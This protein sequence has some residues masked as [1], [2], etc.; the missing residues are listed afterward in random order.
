[1]KARNGILD[2]KID[3]LEN[4][5]KMVEGELREIATIEAA[6]YS[7]VA[8]HMALTTGLIALESKTFSCFTLA[9]VLLTIKDKL[10]QDKVTAGN[11]HLSWGKLLSILVVPRD[12]LS[13]SSVSVTS[14]DLENRLNAFNLAFDERYKK[15]SNWVIS[16]EILRENVCK[17]LVEGII[18]IYR[19]HVK[20]YCLSIENDAK[21]DKYMKYMA[22]SLENKIGSLFQPKQRKVTDLTLAAL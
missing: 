2:N 22:Q 10:F 1:M 9:V 8:D 11:T 3:Y 21:V 7:V 4:K 18:P 6:L 15:Q 16:D 13:P 17:H 12:I 14:Q 5:I 19:A 20:N